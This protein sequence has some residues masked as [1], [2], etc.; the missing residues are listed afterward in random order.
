VWMGFSGTVRFAL[1]PTT[2]V[3]YLGHAVAV[4]VA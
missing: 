1:L 3:Q 4:A 2:V